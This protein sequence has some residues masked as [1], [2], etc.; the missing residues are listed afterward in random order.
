MVGSCSNRR[1]LRGAFTLVELLVVIAIIGIL[2]ALL[3]PAVQSA[4]E[5]ARRTQCV[6]NFKQ[7]GIGFHE[8]HDTYHKLPF[9][10]RN[11]PR[12]PCG[13]RMCGDSSSRSRSGSGTTIRSISMRFPIRPIPQIL[14][15]TARSACAWQPTIVPAIALAPATCRRRIPTGGAKGNYNLNWG[16]HQQPH[17]GPALSGV[18]PFGYMDFADRSKPRISRFN[19]FLDGT[20]NTLLMSEQLVPVRDGDQDHRGDIQNDDEACTYFMTI[21]TPNSSAPDVMVAG[22]CI[23]NPRANLPCVGGANRNKAARSRHP[24]GVNAMNSDGSVRFVRNSISSTVWA[25]DGHD[26]RRRDD[27]Q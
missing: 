6:N 27:L 22:Y 25:G 10:A 20:S 17:P 3:L 1:T 9:A 14:R 26:E 21:N 4:R 7:W 2:I 15:W 19:D 5:S 12:T 24:G 23:S 8:H 13:S 11:N 18:A 16:N